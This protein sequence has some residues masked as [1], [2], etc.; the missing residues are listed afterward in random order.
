MLKG[1][2]FEK[3]TNEEIEQIEEDKLYYLGE[4]KHITAYD[5]FIKDKH[6]QKTT[7]PISN[8][9]YKSVSKSTI[10]F[11]TSKLIRTTNKQQTNTSLQS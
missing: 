2:H 9:V 11:G 6:M 10:A 5:Q 1:Y 8:E 4:Q 7:T 3:L